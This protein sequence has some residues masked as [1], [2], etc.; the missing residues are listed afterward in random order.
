MRLYADRITDDGLI[1]IH[2]SNRYLR[3]E[4]VVAAIAEKC[5]LVCRQRTDDLEEVRNGKSVSRWGVAPGRTSC[6]WIVLAKNPA[7]LDPQYTTYADP[8]AAAVFGGTAAAQTRW[9]EI[10]THPGVDA[11]TDD[12]ASVP[13]VI[14]S[15]EFQWF[16]RKLG[17]TVHPDLEK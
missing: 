7:R 10:P 11:W 3:L 12:Y 4:P 16:R 5:G 14:L 13:Q 9:L 15:K 2:V 17:F 8:G 6:T 1:A